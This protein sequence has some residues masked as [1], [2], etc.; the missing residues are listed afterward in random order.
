VANVADAEKKILTWVQTFAVV[1]V[2]VRSNQS[3]AM[4]VR[5]VCFG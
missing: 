3:A 4:C 2:I 5:T 1:C